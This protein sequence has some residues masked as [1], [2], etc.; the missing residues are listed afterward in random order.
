[1]RE[2][3]ASIKWRT[4]ILLVIIVN[5]P[6][7]TLAFFTLDQTR[8]ALYAQLASDFRAITRRNGVTIN[9][10][11]NHLVLSVGSIAINTEVRDVVRKQNASYGGSSEDIRRKISSTDKSWL[12][13]AANQ[14]VEQML[15]NPASK[16]LRRFVE[17]NPAFKRITVT[18]R[19]GGV[20]AANVKTVDYE[21][22]DEPWWQNAFKDGISGSVVIED[23]TLDPITRF[24]A[25]HVVVPI[26]DE[27]KDQVLG[28]IGALI[29][30]SDLF[31]LVSGVR[32][33]STGETLLV[34]DQG[35]V[36]SGSEVTLRELIPLPYFDD[37]RNAMHSNTRPDFIRASVPGGK[38]KFVAYRDTGLSS[39]Y[40]QLKWMVVTAQDE[41][42]ANA[43]IDTL[44]RKFLW[45]ALANL[46]VITG[47]SLYLFTHRRMRFLD[48]RGP[49]VEE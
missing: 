12:T 16:Y 33:G 5:V 31:P 3:G 46:L 36:I 35:N 44:T 34:T 13:P 40:P 28:I 10:G 6:F 24:N 43:P 22:S 30:I 32:V 19:F 11:I 1:M 15:A 14:M 48:L 21:Q 41:A 27:V 45:A 25:I 17:I 37:I 18:D 39:S 23:V 7:W 26:Q 38:K 8:Q 20:A 42:E 9:Y 47:I 2:D 49:F 29:D 4:V